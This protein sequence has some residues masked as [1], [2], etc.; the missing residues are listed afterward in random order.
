VMLLPRSIHGTGN[1]PAPCGCHPPICEAVIGIPPGWARLQVKIVLNVHD[2][3]FNGSNVPVKASVA[4]V[5]ALDKSVWQE[6]WRKLDIPKPRVVF[7]QKQIT[8]DDAP[9]EVDETHGAVL[10]SNGDD[11]A[12][13]VHDVAVSSTMLLAH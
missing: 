13:V 9:P 7:D 11:F 6:R 2:A 1:Q 5:I 10:P 12:V 3:I 8:E 4:I